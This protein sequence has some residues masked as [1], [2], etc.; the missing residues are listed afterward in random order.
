M[1]G[2]EVTRL[3]WLLCVVF[4]TAALSAEPGST[5]YKLRP[6]SGSNLEVLLDTATRKFDH[7]VELLPDD[8]LAATALFREAGA[9]YTALYDRG[10]ENHRLLLNAGNAWMLAGDVGHAVLAYKRA[11]R[12]RPADTHVQASLAFARSRVAMDVRPDRAAQF[13]AFVLS[14]RGLV[15]RPLV[16]GVV[17]TGYFVLWTMATLRFTPWRRYSR[18]RWAIAI[19]VVTIAA[20]GLIVF[21][22]RLRHAPGEAVIIAPA[23]VTARN[24][25]NEAVYDPAFDQPLPPGVEVR[26]LESRESWLRVRLLDGREAW[27]PEH[28]LEPI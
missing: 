20:L 18:P 3:C 19:G 22:Q 2:R 12:L 11:E 26:V 5:G 1:N 27:V 6:D 25:P 14:W 13:K 28:S 23:G 15:P 17:L 9:A 8:R 7:A 16:V 24:G 4:C 21:D 10:V